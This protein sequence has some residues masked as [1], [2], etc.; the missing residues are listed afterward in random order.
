MT[1]TPATQHSTVWRTPD[2][3]LALAMLVG[4]LLLALPLSRIAFAGHDWVAYFAVAP[5]P[6]FPQQPN[7]SYPPWV[8]SIVLRPLTELPP[9]TGL[10]LVNGLTLAC[11]TLLTYRLARVQ[12]PDQRVSAVVGVLLTALNPL[13]WMLM[14]LGTVDSLMLLGLAALPFGVPLLLL[15]FHI[16]GWAL[17]GSRRDMLWGVGLGIVSL[18]IWGLWPMGI[19]S[20]YNRPDQPPPHPLLMGWQTT[21]PLFVLPG[22]ILFLLC[23]RD[24]LRLIAAGTFITP[25]IM[26]YHFSILLPALGRLRG[27]RQVLL[28]FISLLLPVT[29]GLTSL[30]LKRACFLFPLLVWLLLAPSLRPHDLLHNPDSILNRLLITLR[31][32]RTRWRPPAH[33]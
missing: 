26:P 19:L 15:K 28:W 25:Y 29:S 13:V 11:L 31:D 14:W 3:R 4:G 7:P 18:L 32:L 2:W 1:P 30:E 16:S 8:L 10:A 27:W 22:L 9:R 33:V 24:P 23:D 12:F 21:G 5:D 20:A 17:L 6:V